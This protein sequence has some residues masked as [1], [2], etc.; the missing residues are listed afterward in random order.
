MCEP[1][2]KWTS[3]VGEERELQAE[4]PSGAEHTDPPVR[5]ES[6]SVESPALPFLPCL[7]LLGVAGAL[8]AG[9]PHSMCFMP[10]TT[11]SRRMLGISLRLARLACLEHGTLRWE[12][13]SL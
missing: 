13:N 1:V 10:N 5:A 2:S 12:V 4:S 3:W 11:G 9:F 6:R 7:W 8:P